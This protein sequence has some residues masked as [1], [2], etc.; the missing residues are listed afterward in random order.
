MKKN[1][2]FALIASL[3]ITPAVFA[4]ENYYL[5]L[6]AGA[7]HNLFDSGASFAQLRAGGGV[8]LYKCEKSGGYYGADIHLGTNIS[9][10][11]WASNDWDGNNYRQYNDSPFT[12]YSVDSSALFG[13]ETEKHLDIAFKVG[14]RYDTHH[15]DNS[16]FDNDDCETANNLMLPQIGLAVGIPICQNVKFTTEVDYRFIGASARAGLR[17]VF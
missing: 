8:H 16:S 9:E 15:M 17:Y 2:V 12:F 5:E 4:R 7:D 1:F 3:I 6:D 13:F 14:V 11:K 10:A